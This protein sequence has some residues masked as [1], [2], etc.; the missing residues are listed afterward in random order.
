MQ[1]CNTDSF[2]R[3][4]IS[5]ISLK[6]T[7]ERL[8]KF[9]H[10]NEEALK[11]WNVHII[12]GVDGIQQKELFKR[13]R[14][15]SQNVLHGWSPGAIGSALSHMLTWRLCIQLGK[16]LIIA[17]DDAILAKEISSNLAMLLRD[18]E[19]EIPLL[20]L[21]WNLDSVLQADLFPGLGLISLFEPAYPREEQIAKLVNCKGERHL[22]RLKRCFGLP[23]YRIT[24][25]TA[26][27]L[28]K[29]LNPLTSERIPMGRGIPTNFS[30]T[31]DGALNNHYETIGAK[32]VFPPLGIAVNN[33]SE[34]LTRKRR[35]KNFE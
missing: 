34:S 33:Q 27:F 22:C 9:F 17:E 1:L 12:E 14:I 26:Y 15:I 2:P 16:P 6:R 13:S 5:V 25:K 32:I 7:P 8:E 21:G 3:D 20:L 31:L 11:D 30:E 29:R 19:N 35:I 4:H 10:R 24:P 28:L 18:E 23:A